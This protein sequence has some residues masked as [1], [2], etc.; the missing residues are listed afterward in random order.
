VV[1]P[2]PDLARKTLWAPGDPIS[3]DLVTAHEGIMSAFVS[4]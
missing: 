3:A 2:V 4:G 1:L